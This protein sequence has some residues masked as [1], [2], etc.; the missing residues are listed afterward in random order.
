MPA[1]PLRITQDP[2]GKLLSWLEKIEGVP[3][4]IE[5]ILRE[6]PLRKLRLSLTLFGCPSS[7]RIKPCWFPAMIFSNPAS[8]S[9]PPHVIL[10]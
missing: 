10:L 2:L 4:V 9:P 6:A 8:I 1:I 3:L 7:F 5:S